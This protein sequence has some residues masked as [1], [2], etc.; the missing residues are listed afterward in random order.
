MPARFVSSTTYKAAFAPKS[1]S[2]AASNVISPASTPSMSEQH[3]ITAS[4]N[5]RARRSSGI[6]DKPSFTGR[7]ELHVRRPGLMLRQQGVP[8]HCYN[9][10]HRASS[11]GGGHVLLASQYVTLP[12]QAEKHG[13]LEIRIHA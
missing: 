8:P 6:L 10:R 2:R 4:Q 9:G 3:A 11:G 1:R 5:T 7:I 12:K 13:H